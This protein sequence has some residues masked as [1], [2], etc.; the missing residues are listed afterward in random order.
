MAVELCSE[1]PG[2]VAVMSPRISFSHDLSQSDGSVPIDRPGLD[3]PVLDSDF[4]FC[5]QSEQESS[6]ADELF[7]EGKILPLQFKDSVPVPRNSNTE[8]PHLPKLSS[9]NWSPLPPKDHKKESL[10]KIMA[11]S[12]AEEKPTTSKSFWRFNRSSSLNFGNGYKV[13]LICSLPLLSRSNSTGSINTNARRPPSSKLN[14][15]SLQKSLSNPNPKP[16]IPSTSSSLHKTP[17]KKTNTAGK[18][19]FRSYPN[20]VRISPVLNIPPYI[21][22][23]TTDLFCFGYFFCSGKDTRNK[24]KSPTPQEL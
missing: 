1:T 14:Y 5:I 11:I 21:P 16:S 17:S 7:S 23:G 22:K 18:T 15:N 10:R 8:T 12:D 2:W 6:S 24:K 19:Q 3:P 4:D 13:S 20:T 9:S